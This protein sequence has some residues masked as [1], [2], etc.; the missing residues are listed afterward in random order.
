[1]HFKRTYECAKCEIPRL[2]CMDCVLMFGNGGDLVDDTAVRIPRR[3]RSYQ[4][5]DFDLL[6]EDEFGEDADAANERLLKFLSSTWH[7]DLGAHQ[8]EV[9]GMTLAYA[10]RDVGRFFIFPD[11]SDS[12]KTTHDVAF[13]YFLGS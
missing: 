1:M 12:G 2:R 4:V 11:K 9:M 10:G 8:A 7:G 6:G 13:C 3:R 5:F